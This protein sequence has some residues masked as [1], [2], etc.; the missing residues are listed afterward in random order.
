MTRDKKISGNDF[1]EKEKKDSEEIIEILGKVPADRKG[2]VLGILK[3]FAL[4]A[5]MEKGA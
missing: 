3:G 4:C 5:E 2:E 1:L